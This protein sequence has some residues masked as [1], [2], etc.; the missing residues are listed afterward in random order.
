MKNYSQSIMNYATLH[1]YLGLQ[2]L[3]AYLDGEADIS[4]QTISW[5]LTKLT[6]LGQLHCVVMAR[7]KIGCG[8]KG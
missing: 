6:K 5:Y 1:P 2:D 3:Y 8:K 7:Y 4:Q